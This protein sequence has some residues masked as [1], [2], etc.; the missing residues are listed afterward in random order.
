M[1]TEQ[2]LGLTGQGVEP[3]IVPEIEAAA[4]PMSTRKEATTKAK[5]V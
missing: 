4:Q 2:E 3:V 1:N 5:D